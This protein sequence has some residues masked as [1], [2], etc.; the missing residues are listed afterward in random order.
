[1]WISKNVHRI[2]FAAILIVAAVESCLGATLTPTLS[3]EHATAA[4]SRPADRSSPDASPLAI[5][6]APLLREGNY[7]IDARCTIHKDAVR[8][9]WTLRLHEAGANKS[10]R[11]MLLLPC[12]Q[13][14]E[15]QRLVESSPNRVVE[16][17]VTGRVFV[18][19][20][21]NFVLPSHA[22]VLTPQ[23]PPTQEHPPAPVETAQSMPESASPATAPMDADG[24]DSA[25][26]IIRELEQEA[27][28]LP[29][30]PA[31]MI[32]AEAEEAASSS[33]PSI[34]A[35]PRA[36]LTGRSNQATED[37]SIVNRRGKIMRDS[38]GGW[39]FV[40][41]ADASGLADPPMRLLPCLLLERIEE[42]ARRHGNNSPALMSGQVYL[43]NGQIFLLP[44]VFRVPQ[45]RRNITP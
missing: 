35:E 40:F 15:M 3:Q 2:A 16:F 27:G 28:A 8:G 24:G 20:G 22:P 1:M 18:F 44:T 10:P 34:D 33:L 43:Y 25:E 38:A 42:Y 23:E 32:P 12:T 31:D 36:P 29:R 30:N 13:L 4:S 14:S 45:E 7:I 41:D 37:S 9:W 11:E 19:R 39:T 5:F 6:R 21:R 26:D 17:Q